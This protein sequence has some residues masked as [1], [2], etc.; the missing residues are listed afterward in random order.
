MTSPSHASPSA[1][2]ART[3]ARVERPRRRHL[4][5]VHVLV[6]RVRPPARARP[7]LDRVGVPEEHPVRAGRAAEGLRLR[8]HPPGDGQEPRAG[9]RLARHQPLRGDHHVRAER[10]AQHV[11]HLVVGPV[12]RA[13]D[14]EHRLGHGRRDVPAHARLEHRRRRGGVAEH[15]VD[16][17]AKSPSS[18]SR[19]RA[20]T[21]AAFRNSPSAAA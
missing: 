12:G 21:S 4:G 16:R 1:R 14:V 10:L 9:R 8:P 11:G 5:Q 15:G 18:L 7:A 17:S 20:S 13:A 2:Y 6:R 3:S 19:S